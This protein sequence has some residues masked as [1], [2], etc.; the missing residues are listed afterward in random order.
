MS[1][2]PGT[3]LLAPED[4]RA[5]EVFA[6]AA[7][8]NE[9]CGL[10]SGAEEAGIAYVDG[11]HESENVA[12]E[13]ARRFEID[14][15]LRLRLQRTLRQG[16]RRVVGIYHSHP[17]GLAHPSPRD[18]EA[19]WEPDL[20]WLVIGIRKGQVMQSA[21]HVLTTAEGEA[22]FV[23]IPLVGRGGGGGGGGGAIPGSTDR[24]HAG[25][26][27]ARTSPMTERGGRRQ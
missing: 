21:A 8:P 17:T 19:A 27:M 14:P 22:R 26:R 4:L 1:R 9:C 11:I 18:L 2:V 12:D 25:K 13:P 24:E 23:E 16:G 7:Y 10:L 15:A 5:I 3:V 20:V 6:E